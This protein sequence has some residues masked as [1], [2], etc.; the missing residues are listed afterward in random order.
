MCLT[1]PSGSTILYSTSEIY[2]LDEHPI[3]GLPLHPV[4][5]LLGCIRC[6]HWSRIG[7]PCCGSKPKTR[8]ISSDQYLASWVV[9]WLPSCPCA[10]AAVIRP[11]RLHCA[12]RLFGTPSLRDV[13]HRA[14]HLKKLSIGT[15]N[16]MADAVNLFDCSIGF[17]G[18]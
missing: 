2:L 6:S 18:S 4:T 15:Q 11:D 10:S 9:P 16:W 17:H 7:R 8:N 14:N 12:E 3:T 13:H 5:I 1:V